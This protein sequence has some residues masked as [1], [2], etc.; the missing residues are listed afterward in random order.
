MRT[1]GLL[2][3][4][5]TETEWGPWVRAEQMTRLGL[6]VVLLDAGASASLGL[7]DVTGAPIPDGERWL[8]TEEVWRA[9]PQSPVGAA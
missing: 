5:E 8:C 1:L 2:S 3:P 9:A 4:R 6:G 7:A